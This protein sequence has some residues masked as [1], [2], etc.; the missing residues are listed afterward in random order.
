VIYFGGLTTLSSSAA[1]LAS[2]A[3][4]DLTP[5]FDDRSMAHGV[6]QR[7]DSTAFHNTSPVCSEPVSTVPR[8]IS[9]S[10]CR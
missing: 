7:R 10:S 6:A 2:L 9:S 8:F 5:T 3:E 4:F 1:Y